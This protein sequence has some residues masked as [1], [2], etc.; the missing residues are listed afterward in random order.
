[1]QFLASLM[2][3]ASRPPPPPPKKKKNKKKQATTLE[4][5]LIREVSLENGDDV[6]II[7]EETL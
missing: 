6:T 2:F 5:V 3:V 4:L 1:M 7:F